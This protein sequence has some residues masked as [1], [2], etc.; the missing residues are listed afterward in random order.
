MNSKLRIELF[1]EEAIE[2]NRNRLYGGVT[3]APPVSWQLVSFFLLAILLSALAFA[4]TASYSRT[5][6]VDGLIR[7]E[8]GLAEISPSTD[9]IV[10][11]VLVEEGQQVMRGATLIRLRRGENLADGTPETDPII[12][13]IRDQERSVEVQRQQV[14]LTRNAE[15]SRIKLQAKGWFDEIATLDEQISIQSNLIKTSSAEF[16]RAKA[17]ADRGF[18]SDRDLR[19][20]EENVLAKQ[21]QLAS[22]RQRR[23]AL[24]SR[25]SEVDSIVA[26]IDA[27]TTKDL[28][29]L[30]GR[31]AELARSI[32]N[33]NVR[34]ETSITAPITGRVTAVEARNGNIAEAGSPLM[35]IV[36][37]SSRRIA[38]LHLPSS[39]IGFVEVGQEVSLALDAYPYQTYGTIKASIV[40]VSSAPILRRA[41]D[42]AEVP[43]FTVRAD[44]T[45]SGIEKFGVDKPIL[46]GMA[47]QAIIVTE[48]RSFFQWLF[49][50]LYSVTNR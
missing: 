21:Q 33:E 17:I 10:E 34:A 18:V 42:G 31:S 48:R 41:A 8:G 32:T 29:Q 24:A 2:S 40:S 5:V 9:S 11:A 44:I 22:L 49:E 23:A 14:E 46:S 50:P 15:V 45:P 35:L 27:T 26:A 19:A 3:A 1:R 43:H 13:S 39:A 6:R 36:P 12:A 28:L 30:E 38:E 37:Q 20:R 7:P 4:L 25:L 16:E 47:V